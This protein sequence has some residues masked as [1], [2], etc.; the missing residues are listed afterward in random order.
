MIMKRLDGDIVSHFLKKDPPAPMSYP[1]V[2][3]MIAE[4]IGRRQ[5]A[6]MDALVQ[7]TWAMTQGSIIR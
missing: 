5:W 3:A 1:D 2:A 7:D 4:W 6:D